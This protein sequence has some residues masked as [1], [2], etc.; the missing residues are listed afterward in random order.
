MIR[1]SLLLLL[2]VL[3]GSAA[4]LT[5]E[6][7]PLWRKLPSLDGLIE[8]GCVGE[9]QILLFQSRTELE[10]FFSEAAEKCSGGGYDPRERQ[11]RVQAGL[12]ELDRILPDFD[13]EALVLIQEF[14]GGTGMAKASLDATE[15]EGGVLAASISIR[16][17]P[18]PVTPDTATF[19]FAFAVSKADIKTVELTVNGSERASLSAR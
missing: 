12:E 17:P 8:P 2:L 15:R 18:P 7:T 6:R 4:G 9:N 14:Y 11:R 1:I 10:A 16:I 5:A 19:R 13:K 3:A